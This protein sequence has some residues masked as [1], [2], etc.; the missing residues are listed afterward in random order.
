MEGGR[1]PALTRDHLY[2]LG[3]LLFVFVNFWAYIA[4]SQFMLIWY[5][6]LPEETV[7]FVARWKDGWQW[8]SVLLIIARFAVPYAALLSQDAKMD[9][10]RLKFIALWVLASHWLDLFWLVMP[11]HSPG[12]SLSWVELGFPVLTVGLVMLVLAYKTRRHSLVPAG[13]PKLARAEHFRM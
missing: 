13:D 12:F 2:S 1:I 4:F 9:P 10:K 11:T 6:N 5:A 3:A 7:W 8:A